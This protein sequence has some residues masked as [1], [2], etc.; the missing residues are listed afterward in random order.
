MFTL[1]TSILYLLSFPRK[2]VRQQKYNTYM[3]SLQTELKKARNTPYSSQYKLSTGDTIGEYTAGNAL[4]SGRFATVWSAEALRELKVGG[5]S[6]QSVQ[7]V[8]SVLNK[9][10]KIAIKVYRSGRTN[11]EYWRNEVK[12]L[13][14]LAEKSLLS[15]VVA[16]NIIVFHGSF[17]TVRIDD[18]LEPNIHPCIIFGLAGDSVS[19]LI[20]HCRKEYSAGLPLEYARKVVRDSLRGLEFIHAAGIIHTD[21]K[22]S[23]LLL[24]RPISAINGLE[25]NVL[26]GD[27]GSSTPADDLF[28]QHVG[29]DLYLAPELLLERPYTSAVDIWAIFVT[30]FEL[31]TG[32][33]LFDVF[34]QYEISYGEDVDEEALDGLEQCD[35]S[36]E[37][38]ASQAMEESV[39]SRKD[40]CEDCAECSKQ[41]TDCKDCQNCA[42]CADG[43]NCS[44]QC[45]DRNDKGNM[46]CGSSNG[47][48]SGSEDPEQLGL[49]AY[50]HLLLMEKVLGYPG[51]AFA[52]SAR[53][54]YNARGKLKNNPAIAHISI[55]LLLS[56]NYDMSPEECKVIEAFLLKGL[57][58]N[59]D[60]R[61]TASD[62][63]KL[64][65][66]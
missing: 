5:S 44:N 43:A 8:Q 3:T 33:P 59:P 22:P 15:Q 34:R 10:Q 29:T 58:Y 19:R 65:G 62:A 52:K 13:N 28:A 16:P 12:I 32:D 6:V 41:Y 63:L 53:A 1:I 14:I 7:S 56:Q 23:N 21:I 66:F 2:I 18:L 60:E 25:F 40:R 55:S 27:F 38:D 39:L 61:I 50:R 47:S 45:T 54:Y 36:E 48:S 64:E 37:S 42:E 24:D 11:Q 17:A 30:A 4:G 31:I 26:I 46:E 20:K 51:R 57:K 9:P 49:V 35:S